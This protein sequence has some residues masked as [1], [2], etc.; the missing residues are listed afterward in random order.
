MLLNVGRSKWNI[1]QFN[2][3]YFEDHG[4][5]VWVKWY[6]EFKYLTTLDHNHWSGHA[7]NRLTNA[8]VRFERSE[9]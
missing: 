4:Q 2:E 7:K 3:V 8:G 9:E 6:V 1:L 5:Q